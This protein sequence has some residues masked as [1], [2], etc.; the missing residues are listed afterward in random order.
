MMTVSPTHPNATRARL[1]II[2]TTTFLNIMMIVISCL[3]I[4]ITVDGINIASDNQGC[5]FYFQTGRVVEVSPHPQHNVE[6]E[7]SGVGRACNK[8]CQSTLNG[9]MGFEDA[10]HFSNC[11]DRHQVGKPI[12]SLAIFITSTDSITNDCTFHNS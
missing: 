1:I 2:F 12:I 11:S 9:G 7:I 5:W 6:L 8:Y 3:G 4:S 10:D